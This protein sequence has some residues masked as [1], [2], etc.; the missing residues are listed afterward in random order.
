MCLAMTLA[1]ALGADWAG[2]RAALSSRTLAASSSGKG[3]R[4]DKGQV[5]RSASERHCA[6]RQ[7]CLARSGCCACTSRRAIASQEGSRWA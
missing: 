6:A 7:T 4:P 2:A 1:E 5:R 3:Q